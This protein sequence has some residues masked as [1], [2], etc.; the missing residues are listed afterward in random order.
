MKASFVL[1]VSLGAS[2]AGPVGC[3][4]DGP[5]AQHPTKPGIELRA[6]RGE[7]HEVPVGSPP[8]TEGAIVDCPAERITRDE[9]GACFYVAPIQ[10]PEAASCNPPP[11]VPVRCPETPRVDPSAAHA[12]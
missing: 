5:G 3:G 6:E 4:H 7:C 12:H 9:S 11:P 2:F 1:T 8:E 10:C